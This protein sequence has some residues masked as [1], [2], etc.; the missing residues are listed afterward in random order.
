MPNGGVNGG[1]S[2]LSPTTAAAIPTRRKTFAKRLIEQ[3]KVDVIDRRHDH[4]RDHGGDAGGRGRRA[5]RSFRSPAPS[6]IVEP[7]KT[8]V[9][10]TPHT[11]RMACEKI[12]EP[13]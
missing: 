7:V 8:W 4:R 2:S 9:F 5:C 6:Q 11:D 3:D 12:F 1:R 10:K 13:T